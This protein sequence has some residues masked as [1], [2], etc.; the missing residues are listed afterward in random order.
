MDSRKEPR[1]QTEQEVAVTLLGTP[2]I[3]AAGKIVNLSGKGLCLA[4]DR[5]L[6]PGRAL[7][8]E[9]ACCWEKWCIAGLSRRAIS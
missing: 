6:P 8:V 2:E 7:K 3:R 5:E 1:L 4:T 9:M